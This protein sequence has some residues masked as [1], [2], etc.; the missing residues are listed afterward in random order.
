VAGLEAGLGLSRVAAAFGGGGGGAGAAAGS[1]K[2][3]R[4]AEVEGSGIASFRRMANATRAPIRAVWTKR[5][6]GN[7][8]ERSAWA[9]V[10]SRY[11]S[12]VSNRNS[13]IVSSSSASLT[14]DIR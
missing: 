10:P 5:D 9:P 7:V 4:T 12:S 8:K 1:T 14:V 3:V 6:R 2:K 13:V 11:C